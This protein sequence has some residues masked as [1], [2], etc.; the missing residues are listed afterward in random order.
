[1]GTM[2][3]SPVRVSVT[4]KNHDPRPSERPTWHWWYCVKIRTASGQPLDAPIQLRVQILSGRTLLQGVEQVSFKKGYPKHA[5]RGAIGGEA[6][7]L[8]AAPR[9]KKLVLQAVV[10]AKGET[11]ERNWSIVVR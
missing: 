11:V 10:R 7:V 3:Q 2:N 9:E 8:Y 6:N 1:M 5:W 4:A